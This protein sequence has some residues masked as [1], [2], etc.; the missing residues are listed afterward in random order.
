MW[1]L[2]NLFEQ[3]PITPE[4][5]FINYLIHHI[6]PSPIKVPFLA[7]CRNICD[8]LAFLLATVF[9]FGCVYTGGLVATFLIFGLSR[10]PSSDPDCTSANF[11][12]PRDSMTEKR[13]ELLH[14]ED[15]APAATVLLYFLIFG[16]N[17]SCY[18]CHSIVLR[19]HWRLSRS[20]ILP[21]L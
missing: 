7:Q 1:Y 11:F 14:W 13:F 3:T 19:L 2:D 20:E 17:F 21:L 8:W 12:L 10:I 16:L 4:F 9:F 18:G 6:L 5:H 15:S